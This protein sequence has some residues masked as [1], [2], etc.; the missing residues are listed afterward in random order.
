MSNR[1]DIKGGAFN[2][3]IG[4]NK[5]QTTPSNTNTPSNTKNTLE[6][7]KNSI[8]EDSYKYYNGQDKTQ[9]YTIT[10]KIDS[11]IE[12]YLRCIDKITFLE[13]IQDETKESTTSTDYVNQLIREDMKRRFKID[14]KEQDPTKWINAFKEY[15]KKYNLKDEVSKKDINRIKNNPYI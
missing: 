9:N 6:T 4:V 7:P 5:S 14:P 15:Q 8:I 3:F 13:S 1:D 12:Q 10:F 2:N 11:D